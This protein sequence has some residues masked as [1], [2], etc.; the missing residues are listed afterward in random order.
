MKSTGNQPINSRTVQLDDKQQ[1]TLAALVSMGYKLSHM[2]TL[3]GPVGGSRIND[4]WF[5]R[6]VTAM[7]AA[8]YKH[9]HVHPQW[10]LVINRGWDGK[11]EWSAHIVWKNVVPAKMKFFTW[12]WN[13]RFGALSAVMSP[14]TSGLAYFVVNMSQPESYTDE[15]AFN[16]R[17]TAKRG[18]GFLGD[19]DTETKGEPS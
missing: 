3:T 14:H 7:M 18:K 6:A 19:A 12:W 9:Y 15:G 8:Y 4:A 10:M 2:L 13:K 5:R 1:E 17:N 11:G 16:E